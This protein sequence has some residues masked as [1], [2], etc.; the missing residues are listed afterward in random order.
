MEKEQERVRTT[1]LL[2]KLVEMWDDSC[3]ER[4]LIELQWEE[5]QLRHTLLNQNLAAYG[6]L[7]VHVHYEKEHNKRVH[8]EIERL[9]MEYEQES[10]KKKKK[11]ADDFEQEFSK[12]HE[13]YNKRKVIIEEL[14]KEVESLEKVLKE[15]EA[16]AST[17]QTTV[18]RL[19]KE[20]SQL[21]E[22]VKKATEVRHKQKG[23]QSLAVR[24][25]ETKKKNQE[26]LQKQDDTIQKLKQ[27]LGIEGD[28]SDD[29]TVMLDEEI[30]RYRT[31]LELADF[32]LMSSSSANFRT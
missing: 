7:E 28:V 4:D 11:L 20:T 3:K 2:K 19:D 31:L 8:A 1:E 6:G 17:L 12:A 5:L 15:E 14:T 32:K 23:T 29:T 26:S 22:L 30:I 10:I 25:A 27:Q 21:H 13:T 16:K 9:Q 18:T 24:L